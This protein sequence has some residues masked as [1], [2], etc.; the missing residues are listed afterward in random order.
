MD[1]V[2]LRS[3]KIFPDKVILVLLSMRMKTLDL[4]GI[5][6]IPDLLSQDGCYGCGESG[7]THYG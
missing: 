1:M 7:H 6:N 5:M 2:V 3:D 4:K